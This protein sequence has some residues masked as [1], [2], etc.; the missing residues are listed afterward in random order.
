MN[1]SPGHNH[2]GHDG[3]PARDA[4]ETPR[5]AVRSIEKITYIGFPR[6]KIDG[7][8]IRELFE[9]AMTLTQKHS[10]C[11]LIDLLGVPMVSSGAMGIFVE[12]QKKFRHV[13]GQL[14]LHVPDPMIRQQFQVM[15]LHVL[16]LL[17]DT[18]DEAQQF[19]H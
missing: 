11:L 9:A 8:T 18:L 16:L 6:R 2:A 5:L 12:I 19:K 1:Q 10:P 7:I 17:F 15:N 13:G 4:E 3:Q 14:H